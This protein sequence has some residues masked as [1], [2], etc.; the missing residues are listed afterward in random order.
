MKDPTLRQLRMF[1]PNIILKLLGF[2][3]SIVA[4][5]FTEE[6][7]MFQ[8]LLWRLKT[9]EFRL[10]R[11]HCRELYLDEG[12]FELNCSVVIMT[13]AYTLSFRYECFCYGGQ[14]EELTLLG[15]NLVYVAV[16]LR[17]MNVL[18]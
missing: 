4:F 15:L 11:P 17:I 1:L 5:N 10:S 3:S 2:H 7:P 18:S 14:T 6:N 13:K 9:N 12:A 16:K 8:K